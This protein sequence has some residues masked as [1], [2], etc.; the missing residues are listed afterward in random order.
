MN[1]D[2]FQELMECLNGI[3]SRL[4][5]IESAVA[6]LNVEQGVSTVDDVVSRLDGISSALAESSDSST[7]NNLDDV[8]SRL[9]EISSAVSGSSD[10]AAGTRHVEQILFRTV[11]YTDW[12][13]PS[14]A[15]A[16][17]ESESGRQLRSRGRDG[18]TDQ[19]SPSNATASAPSSTS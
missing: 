12:P 4:D 17:G 16:A 8:V 19:N 11:L 3:S 5:A 14:K 10:T 18:S 2:Q 7:I 6:D 13:A 9:D 1:N 15:D